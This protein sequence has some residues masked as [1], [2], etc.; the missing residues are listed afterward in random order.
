MVAHLLSF[1]FCAKAP[2]EW[3][4]LL[5][6]LLLVRYAFIVADFF[7]FILIFLCDCSLLSV[8]LIYVVWQT[9][10]SFFFKISFV[11]FSFNFFKRPANVWIYLQKNAQTS[12]INEGSSLCAKPSLLTLLQQNIFF[13]FLFKEWTKT[14]MLF[15]LKIMGSFL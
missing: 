3:T 11:S 12:M 8:I 4:W 5:R 9:L 6:S 10:C 14:R 7:S 13:S 15:S 1:V 2:N